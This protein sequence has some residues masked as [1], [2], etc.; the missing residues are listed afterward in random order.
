MRYILFTQPFCYKCPSAEK[1]MIH[2]PY[3]GLI[4]NCQKD[5]S[6]AV[7][8]KILQTPTLL[9]INDNNKEVGRYNSIEDIKLFVEEATGKLL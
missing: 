8:F 9:I 5:F 4:V 3:K 2:L 1:L 7:K 6:E